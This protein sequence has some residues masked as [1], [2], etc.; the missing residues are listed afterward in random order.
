MRRRELRVRGAQETVKKGSW[1]AGLEYHC[2]MSALIFFLVCYD[3]TPEK[4]AWLDCLAMMGSAFDHL[5][6]DIT[7]TREREENDQPNV[8]F[9][10]NNQT[11][12][13]QYH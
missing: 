3:A 6:D 13:A 10:C 9:C 7:N 8:D 12:V 1:V 11:R 2:I 4:Y 5:F